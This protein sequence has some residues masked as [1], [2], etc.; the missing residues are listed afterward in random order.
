MSAAAQMSN[1][2]L[3]SESSH[4]PLSGSCDL[5]VP[6]RFA[7][8]K[9]TKSKETL[10]FFPCEEL[11]SGGSPAGTGLVNTG[12]P[13]HKWIKTASHPLTAANQRR[14]HA[15]GIYSSSFCQPGTA[16]L[17]PLFGALVNEGTYHDLPFLQV[18]WGNIPE[19]HAP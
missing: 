5:H 1:P 11:I 6:S 14:S 15:P 9:K 13:E 10:L 4:G 19:S 8:H 3:P 7:P 12:Q 17:P 2:Y 18:A 16:P